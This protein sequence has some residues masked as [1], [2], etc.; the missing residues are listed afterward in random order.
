M[1]GRASD[2]ILGGT[3]SEWLMPSFGGTVGETL[4]ITG[5]NAGTVVFN[6][7]HGSIGETL[8]IT[9]GT[10]GAGR[11]RSEVE[12]A[13]GSLAKSGNVPARH[14]ACDLVTTF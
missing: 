2:T 3:Y 13:G 5:G 12:P 10:A 6:M 11:R 14:T 1:D 8:T 9:G 4:T 7:A